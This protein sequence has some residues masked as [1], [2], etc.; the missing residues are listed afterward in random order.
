MPSIM[1]VVIK[2]MMREMKYQRNYQ[3]GRFVW[4]G[5]S[6][7]TLVWFQGGFSRYE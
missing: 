4:G 1:T 7:G 2:D 3:Q 6:Q 5:T